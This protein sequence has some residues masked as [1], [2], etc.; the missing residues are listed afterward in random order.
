MTRNVPILHDW[1][2]GQ[3]PLSGGNGLGAKQGT[4]A[5][6]LYNTAFLMSHR[7]LN[8]KNMRLSPVSPKPIATR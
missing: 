2:R 3:A 8:I 7:A 1:D 5:H 6:F 4:C